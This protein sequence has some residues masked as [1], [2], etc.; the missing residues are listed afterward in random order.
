MTLNSQELPDQDSPNSGVA[1]Q[2][3]L[4]PTSTDQMIKLKINIPNVKPYLTIQ[5][6]CLIVKQIQPAFPLPAYGPTLSKPL[7]SF[8]WKN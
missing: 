5:P 2:D 7:I 3:S 1:C 6:N 4:I 8:N